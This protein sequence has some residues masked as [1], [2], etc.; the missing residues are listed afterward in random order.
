MGC[1]YIYI[2]YSINIP[3]AKV[4]RAQS[5]FIGW[6]VGFS[7]K[8]VGVK[9]RGNFGRKRSWFWSS[10]KTNLGVV[11]GGRVW[12]SGRNSVARGK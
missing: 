12:A 5:F 7:A 10:V 8:T 1:L 9:G 4:I 3:H 2:Y 11:C 6:S